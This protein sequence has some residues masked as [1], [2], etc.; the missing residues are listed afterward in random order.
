MMYVMLSRTWRFDF[1]QV[2]ARRNNDFDRIRRIT[3]GIFQILHLWND[4]DEVNVRH[5]FTHETRHDTKTTDLNLQLPVD[6]FVLE[7][8]DKDSCGACS[9]PRA[10]R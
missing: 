10:I 9:C 2:M 6:D 4:P 7:R 3:G 1:D 8:R 5:G